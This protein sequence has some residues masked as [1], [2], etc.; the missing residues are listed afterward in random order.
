[1]LTSRL[2]EVE[3]S[4]DAVYEQACEMGWTDGLPVIP[5]TEERVRPFVDY[6]KRDPAEVIAKIPPN[7]GAAAIEKIAINAVM[8]GCRPEYMPVLLAAVRAMVE[9]EF[10]L[11]GIQPTTGPVAPFL[12]INGPIRSRLGIN[13]GANALGPGCH[14]NATVG[15][16]LR[17]I[18]V[19]VG[20]ALP[21]T[22]DKAALGQPGKYTM[23]LGENEEA[24]PWEPL[25]VERGLA[26]ELSAV[27][28]VAANST[29]NIDV[30]SNN[31]ET[32]LAVMIDSLA[33]L[34]QSNRFHR[35][36]FS[37]Q[38]L[39][40]NPGHASVLARGGF[41]KQ[42]LKEYLRQRARIPLDCFPPE[43]A[44]LLV[45]CPGRVI[46][47]KVVMWLKPEDLVV[48]V[49]GEAGIHSTFVPSWANS[50][51]VTKTIS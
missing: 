41:S 3:A 8:A 18:L 23:C 49:A 47:N 22:V 13:C 6:L 37:E 16:A 20:G 24:S 38:T 39:I 7:L 9:P 26:P 35:V 28:A 32:I 25:H 17:F 42:E 14:A 30:A 11:T 46:D 31:V 44:E 10:N 12:L 51:S 33:C 1:M 4:I 36:N 2:V 34:G 27:T 29:H 21:G 45:S 48:I 19:N 43:V 50:K 40:I 15:R 5:P